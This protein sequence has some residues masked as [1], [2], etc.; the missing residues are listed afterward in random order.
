MKV[1][2]L[3]RSGAPVATPKRTKRL[4]PGRS[5]PGLLTAS[6]WRLRLQRLGWIFGAAF[7]RG[8]K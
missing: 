2:S 5:V 6:R 7:A 8:T 3:T 4:R 1:T